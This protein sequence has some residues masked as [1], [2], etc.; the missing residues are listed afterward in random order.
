MPLQ[1]RTASQIAAD[2]LAGLAPEEE[3]PVTQDAQSIAER[4]LTPEI[5]EDLVGGEI[6]DILPRTETVFPKAEDIA[7]DLLTEPEELQRRALAPRAKVDFPLPFPTRGEKA[8]PYY[9]KAGKPLRPPS[10]E[11]T[12]G[13]LKK[14]ISE[15]PRLKPTRVPTVEGVPVSKDPVFN[16][17]VDI[18]GNRAESLALYAAAPPVGVILEGINLLKGLLIK[19]QEKYETGESDINL[20]E[21]QSITGKLYKGENEIIRF[22]LETGEMGV[23]MVVAGIAANRFK[24]STINK[25]LK[26][27]F[28]KEVAAG[29]SPV[30]ARAA[31]E[32]QFSEIG[33]ADAIDVARGLINAV[34]YKAPKKVGKVS[35]LDKPRPVFTK[36]KPELGEPTP[37][38]VKVVP[39]VE[40]GVDV[41]IPPKLSV[42][43]NIKR[44]TQDVKAPSVHE[45]LWEDLKE[46]EIED[47]GMEE[48]AQAS[49]TPVFKGSKALGGIHADE[50][51]GGM[52]YLENTIIPRIDK[53]TEAQG[54]KALIVEGFDDTTV[55]KMLDVYVYDEAKVQ[56]ILDVNEIVISPE[57]FI[58]LAGRE[59]FAA[60][61]PE[62]T[63]IDA[64]YEVSKVPTKELPGQRQIRIKKALEKKP[65]VLP[66]PEVVPVKIGTVL[67]KGDFY[68]RIEAETPTIDT[69]RV[70]REDGKASR[71][72]KE[73]IQKQFVP[74]PEHRF[75]LPEGIKPKVETI[76]IKMNTAERTVFDEQIEKAWAESNAVAEDIGKI[77]EVMLRTFD[78]KKAKV[79]VKEPEAFRKAMVNYIN[80]AKSKLTKAGKQEFSEKKLE[81]ISEAKEVEAKDIPGKAIEPEG[82]FFPGREKAREVAKGLAKS[83]ATRSILERR[84]GSTLTSPV[85]RKVFKEWLDAGGDITVDALVKRVPGATKTSVGRWIN[86]FVAGERKAAFSGIK[87]KAGIEA[88]I[89]KEFMLG[90]SPEGIIE[91]L[92]RDIVK[93]NVA[94]DKKGLEPLPKVGINKVNSLVST[95]FKESEVKKSE[96]FRDIK[97]KAEKI[98]DSEVDKLMKEATELLEDEYPEVGLGIKLVKRPPKGA[99][100]GY[101]FKSEEGGKRFKNSK[102]IKGVPFTTRLASYME[103]IKN[104]MSRTLIHLPNTA[105]WI[106]AKTWIKYLEKQPSVKHEETLRLLQAETADLPDKEAMELFELKVI[107]NDLKQE[108][109]AERELPWGYTKETALEELASIDAKLKDYPEVMKAVNKRTKAR[110]ILREYYISSLKD[111]GPD[112]SERLTK[113]DYF[114]HQILEFQKIDRSILIGRK[115]KTPIGRRWLRERKGSEMDMLSDYLKAES[116]IVAQMMVDIEIAKV[117]KLMLD[118]YDISAK[119]HADAKKQGLP[120]TEWYKAIPEKHKVVQLRP[121]NMF[122]LANSITERAMAEILDKGFA[123]LPEVQKRL[124]D[125]TKTTLAVG[126]KFHEAVFPDE[127]ANTIMDMDRVFQESTLA[128]RSRKML[129]AWKVWAILSPRRGLKF[130][131]RN[132]SGDLDHVLAGNPSSLKDVPKAINALVDVFFTNKPIEGNLRKFH[133]RGGFSI[134]QQSQE[135]GNTKGLKMFSRLYESNKG[136]IATGAFKQYWKTIKLT[137]DFRESILRYANFINYQGQMLADVKAGGPGKPK[138]FGASLREEIM[139]MGD[140][141]DRAYRMANE[142]LLPYDE[143]SQF[144]AA[145]RRHIYPFWSWKELNVR[146]YYRLFKNALLDAD[147]KRG[148]GTGLMAGVRVAKMGARMLMSL[149]RFGLKAGAFLAVVQTWN[150]TMRPEVEA[151]L[152]EDVRN[153]PHLNFWLDKAGN[154]VA[155]TRLGA[156][157]DAL[158][159]FG[160]DATPAMINSLVKGEMSIKEIAWQLFKAPINAIIHGLHPG[161]SL[162]EALAKKSLYPEA[163]PP[164]NIAERGMHIARQLGVADEYTAL[165]GRP[166]KKYK[167]TLGGLFVYKYEAEEVAYYEARD[168]A[169]E[170][171]K[172]FGKGGVSGTSPKSKALYNMKKSR[173]YGR[174]KLEK[175]FFDQY[176]KY[177]RFEGKHLGKDERAI[178]KLV[179][180][181]IASSLSSLHP[182]SSISKEHSKKFKESLTEEQRETIAKA[183][184]YY[185]D[186]LIGNTDIRE[187]IDD[188]MNYW[189][190]EK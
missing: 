130:M 8:K 82:K 57:E 80:T 101:Q 139:A 189:E 138:N 63:A 3:L 55:G 107:F 109:L 175:K 156:L 143:I 173:K 121:G 58:E 88:T 38:T 108:A 67:K 2:I 6:G 27:L 53:A 74:A 10:E 4:L 136:N 177:V 182:T 41:T 118:R 149:G 86:Q 134:T 25:M 153:Q 162:F 163:L 95:W 154:P 59:S 114:P 161:K 69:Y 66:A 122:Y 16:K 113:K 117:I 102:E 51:R 125:A 85:Q 12:I 135:I 62:R 170:Y 144:G 99:A 145:F 1:V 87:P 96:V 46:I 115:M 166:G 179:K 29:R 26:T 128:R 124:R 54:L 174:S 90:K 61:T 110:D 50:T 183:I 20:L 49:L 147:L 14:P 89:F 81:A 79:T 33:D 106:D 68:Y 142:L 133:R 150:L 77:E 70:V 21:R 92:N 168:I 152:P 73:F 123:S 167:E 103:D 39:N 137:N 17:F 60:K 13:P 34:K 37:T 5:P 7:Q 47:P 97:T 187:A 64:L 18:L 15:F 32:E 127:V 132:I 176:V 24:S 43:A 104:S 120:K 19:E 129:V 78:P 159:M 28:K 155:F 164:S 157:Q 45:V 160:L 75:T 40:G 76:D 181:G 146:T 171:N 91:K 131:F 105:E 151:A 169:F 84:I 42:K 22:L 116:S 98:Y 56:V 185:N 93:K 140:I 72:D 188:I 148:V 71:L 172:E 52:E 180:R 184:K 178:R 190:E 141:D 35:R 11:R 186:V 23:E 158:E 65:T 30:A 48:M 94:R 165:F 119:V 112:V 83:P 36:G 100:K 111:V 44:I 31:I 9:D 126:G